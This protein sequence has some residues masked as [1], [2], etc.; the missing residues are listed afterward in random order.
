[1]IFYY[2]HIDEWLVKEVVTKQGMGVHIPVAIFCCYWPISNFDLPG[3]LS[4]VENGCMDDLMEDWELTTFN[5][6]FVY[7]IY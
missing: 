4:R 7:Y 2:C 1:M 6:F 3:L 5:Y